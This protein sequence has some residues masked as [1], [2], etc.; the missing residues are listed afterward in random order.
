ML[1]VTWCNL[2]IHWDPKVHYIMG[3]PDFSACLN[4]F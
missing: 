2:L 1:S 3:K 4:L